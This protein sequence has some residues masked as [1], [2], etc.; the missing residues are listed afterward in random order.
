M[1]KLNCFSRKLA[2][3]TF[4]V[5][6]IFS[7]P[8]VSAVQNAGFIDQAVVQIDTSVGGASFSAVSLDHSPEANPAINEPGCIFYMFDVNDPEAAMMYSYLVMAK[9]MGLRASIGFEFT[10]NPFCVAESILV[11]VE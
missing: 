4:A 1:K 8:W 3:S 10:G 9:T 11:T 5:C 6:S 7:S 2:V